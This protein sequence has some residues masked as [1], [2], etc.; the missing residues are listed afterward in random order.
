MFLFPILPKTRKARRTAKS[1]YPLVV[2]RAREPVFYESYAV[3]DTFTGRFDMISLHAGLLVTRAKGD[4]P[5]GQRLAQALFDEMFLKMDMSCRQAGI[6][7]LGVP[8]HMKRMMKA[9]QGRALHYEQAVAEG[10]DSVKDA[11]RRNLYGTVDAPSGPV[12]DT[13]A[14]YVA[15]YHQALKNQTLESIQNGIQFPA[16]PEKRNDEISKVA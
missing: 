7:D 3:P 11:L 4:S 1:L 13:M 5:D 9:F 12:L 10:R 14:D 15:A 6:G 2:A 16:L 8:K